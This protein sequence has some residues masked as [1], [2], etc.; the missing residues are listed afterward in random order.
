[1]DKMRIIKGICSIDCILNDQCDDG[2]TLTLSCVFIF[3]I[4]NSISSPGPGYGL[5]PLLL[6]Y[7]T[8]PQDTHPLSLVAATLRS[9]HGPGPG[10]AL[11]TEL[12]VTQNY[13]SGVGTLNFFVRLFWGSFV[14]LSIVEYNRSSPGRQN[15]IMNKMRYP[16]SEEMMCKGCP[17][18][19]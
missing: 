7:S 10:S 15:K 11:N 9:S 2:I 1:M 5:T 13:R 6:C 17:F 3:Y 16:V 4:F 19:C 14:S 8:L 18:C 12:H